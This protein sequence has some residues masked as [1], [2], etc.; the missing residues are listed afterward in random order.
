MNTDI[1]IRRPVMTTLIMAGLLI[2][3]LMAYGRCR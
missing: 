1:F 2:S 3:G